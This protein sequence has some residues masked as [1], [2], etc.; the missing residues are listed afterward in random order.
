LDFRVSL[1]VV[2]GEFDGSDAALDLSDHLFE[3]ILGGR[4]RVVFGV[5]G[6]IGSLALLLLLCCWLLLARR[7]G[8]ILAGLDFFVKLGEFSFYLGEYECFFIVSN[9]S[10]QFLDN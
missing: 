9:E 4:I 8:F 7:S 3:E 1:V 5:F 6:L 2:L 10:S